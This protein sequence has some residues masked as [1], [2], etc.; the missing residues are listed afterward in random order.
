VAEQ[1]EAI[2][3]RLRAVPDTPG[4]Y[5]LRDTSEQVIYVGKALRLRDRLRSYFTPGYANTAR[6]A[7]LVRR[8]HDFEF[9]TAANEVEALVL[10]HNLI[11]HY[12]P[13]FNIRLR[14]DKNYL[15]LKLPVQE[16]F[17]RVH[18]ARRVG[19]DGALYFG[20]YT[21][22]QSLRGTVK[23]L[24]QLLPFRTCSDDIFKQHKV[25]LDFHIKRCPGP[26]EGRIGPD[27]YMARIH[28]VA[29]FM[30]GH[31][32]TLTKELRQRMQD[33]ADRLDFE[34][35]ARYRDQLQAIEKIADRQKVLTRSRDDQDLVA[36]ARAGAD[37]YVEV[38][39]I[40]QGK[41][42]GHD[43]HSLEGAGAA[44]EP[45][46]LRGFLLQYYGSA[47]H[48]PRTV[49]LPGPV[50][51]PELMVGWLTQ[52]RDGPVDLEVP[53][54]GRK[55][56]LVGQLAETAAEE[57]KQRR[58]Q[59]DY[60]RSRTEPM[61]QAL[62]DA[63]ELDNPPHRIECYDIS[64]LQGEAATGAM[65]VFE[66]GRPKNEHYRHF[67]IKRTQGPNDFAMLQEVMR[68]RLER[69][70]QALRREDSVEVADRSFSTMPDLIL[71]DG[72]KG[73]LSAVLEVL[74]ERGFADI[75]TFGLAKEREHI[76]APNR[77]EP[78]VQE[79][80]SPGMFLVQRIRDEA[81][82]WAITLHRKV[83]SKKALSSPLDSVEGIGPARRRALLRTFGSLQAIREASVDQIVAAGISRR[84]A[85]R[86]KE[87]L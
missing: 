67:K 37:V 50:L 49:V 16:E 85:V 53:Q 58:I 71:V 70:E 84:V 77:S 23:S 3:R 12:R 43:G 56:A 35:A 79:H 5:L 76:F 61:L 63:L 54:R 14:D 33:T 42:V 8:V 17:P 30:E 45:E 20:P 28:Q 87:L 19:Q 73:Q 64:N 51:E 4:V 86:L 69:L 68:R 25:C 6:V 18:Y 2:R 7:D 80:N 75:P 66:D 60:D 59:A 72:G 82:R 40:R 46:L 1:S 32:D 74:E 9:V 83:R 62:A 22:A 55:K 48:I 36:Y 29:L 78:I 47:T 26:C 34:N 38:A 81:H 21:S 44:E 15:Y 27:D 11:K 13:K 41:M 39:Y 52:R 65:V 57:L 24:R 31:S 10:E